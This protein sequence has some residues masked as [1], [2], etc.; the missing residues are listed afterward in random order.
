RA[1]AV[2]VLRVKQWPVRASRRGVQGM[3][4]LLRHVQDVVS[5]REPLRYARRGYISMEPPRGADVPSRTASSRIPGRD[6]SAHV[7]RMRGN[8]R[9]L[10]LRAR[11]A[12]ADRILPRM[13]CARHRGGVMTTDSRGTRSGAEAARNSRKG[14]LMKIL[15][16]VILA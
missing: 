4:R 5:Q 13:R 9:L 7:L 6:S 1:K 10:R 14:M 3:E 8:T 12:K 2:S 11:P 16:C 15:L